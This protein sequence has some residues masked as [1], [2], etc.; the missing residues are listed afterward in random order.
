MGRETMEGEKKRL[1]WSL[2]RR[3]EKGKR[4]ERG[5]EGMEREKEGR[6]G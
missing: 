2:K 1:G 5:R 4:N 3:G 6:N